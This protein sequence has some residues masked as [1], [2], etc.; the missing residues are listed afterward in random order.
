MNAVAN[1]KPQS[2]NLPA[3]F[4][5]LFGDPTKSD[6]SA[7]IS[8]G[9][10]PVIHYKG[11]V[12]SMTR[13]G[14]KE[15]FIDENGD[16]R[17]SIE[18]VMVKAAP[19]LSKTWYANKFVDGAEAGKPDCYSND[20]KAPAADSPKP[21]CKT[22]AACKHNQFGS[23]VSSDG[24]GGKGKACQDVKRVA[25]VPAGALNDPMLLRVPPAS[26]KNLREFADALA[27][28]GVPYQV[29]KVRLG[30]DIESAS[31]KLTFKPVG[32][33]EEADAPALAELATTDLIKQITGEI[34]SDVPADEFEEGTPEGTDPETGELEAKQAA[35]AAANAK[36]EADAKAKA[37]KEAEAK[38]KA[39]KEAEA[40]EAAAA[41]EA[42]ESKTTVVNNDGDLD[43]F[44]ATL[45]A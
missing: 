38:A 22:C 30:F 17:P 35:E 40:Q 36:K 45:G 9:G 26:L 18:V 42:A 24:V 27:K 3:L 6:L 20:G 29:V 41:A 15:N 44:L 21:Q 33:I 14:E 32:F 37:K 4:S 28:R 7:G 43:D 12:W 16:P 25:V 8:A 5:Q 10:F 11:K 34:A 13:S 39:K 1:T 2:T 23:A 19:H 31:P